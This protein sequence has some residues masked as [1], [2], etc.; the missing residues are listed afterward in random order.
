MFLCFCLHIQQH[1][2]MYILWLSVILSL[3]TCNCR[4]MITPCHLVLLHS[5]SIGVF[6]CCCFLV[7]WSVFMWRF[8][9]FYNYATNMAIFPKYSCY[10]FLVSTH[11][12][13]RIRTGPRWVKPDSYK[14]EEKGRNLS[15]YTYKDVG[16]KGRKRSKIKD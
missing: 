11:L 6:C 12:R 15:Q 14:F 5:L 16:E 13:Y 4:L 1:H 8:Q 10:Y 2:A 7:V 9:G 3:P